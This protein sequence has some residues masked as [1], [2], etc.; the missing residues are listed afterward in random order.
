MADE[1]EVT[2]D[3]EPQQIQLSGIPVLQDRFASTRMPDGSVIVIHE[4]VTPVG[5]L[6]FMRPHEYHLGVMSH[7]RK[8]AGAGSLQVAPAG[9]PL[10]P[11]PG[12]LIR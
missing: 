5:T 11:P 3:E 4:V 6:R 12:G 1:E 2:P 7:G 8:A 9:T 10:P